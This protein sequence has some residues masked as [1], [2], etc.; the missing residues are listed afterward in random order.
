GGG[1][2]PDTARDGSP[3]FRAP[4]PQPPRSVRFA[5]LRA[6]RV[7]GAG[8][9]E[10]EARTRASRGEPAPPCHPSLRSLRRHSA[11]APRRCSAVGLCVSSE[12]GKIGRASCRVL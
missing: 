4:C 11:F 5:Y 12:V 7:Q 10:R 3:R 9:P 1:A 8:A 6:A 2:G